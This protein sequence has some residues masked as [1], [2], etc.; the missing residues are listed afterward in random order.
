[1]TFR[2]GSS[3]DGP[4]LTEIAHR[5][6]RGWGYPEDWI[7]AWRESLTLRAD[8]MARLEVRI[9]RFERW[10]VGFAALISTEGDRGQRQAELEHLWVVPECWGMGVGTRL[11]TWVRRAAI[12]QG[13]AVLRIESDP[14]AEA[15]YARMGA[16]RTTT[17]ESTPEGR[18][19]PVLELALSP[20]C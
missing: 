2:A 9:A 11:F 20:E 12:A 18:R 15:F 10:D 14:N 6:K 17:V 16:R 7:A 19:L 5:A 4:A 13:C 8:T 3:S 1:M